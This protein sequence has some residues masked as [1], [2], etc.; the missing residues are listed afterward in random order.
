MSV[1]KGY[2][3]AGD[4]ALIDLDFGSGISAALTF[5]VEFYKRID[6]R[7]LQL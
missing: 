7:R 5:S 2:G 6:L 3:S 1:Q 4:W